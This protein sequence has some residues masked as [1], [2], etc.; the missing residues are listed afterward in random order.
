[1]LIFNGKKYFVPFFTVADN[2]GANALPS[3]VSENAT[4]IGANGVPEKGTMPHFGDELIRLSLTKKAVSLTP[5]YHSDTLVEILTEKEK[6]VTPTRDGVT[7]SPKSGYVLSTVKVMGDDNLVSSNIKK[8][9]SIFG[10]TG[11]YEVN[12]ND[13]ELVD[14]RIRNNSDAVLIICNQW[15]FEQHSDVEQIDTDGEYYHN[16]VKALPLFIFA[17]KPIECEYNNTECH[18]INLQENII[19]VFIIEPYTELT[20]F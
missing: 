12:N 5:G 13:L 1:M 8:D 9:V 2:T 14:V 17:D 15:G 11:S 7:V 19:S 20:I 6:E 18:A 10:V 16:T 4:F 3:Q